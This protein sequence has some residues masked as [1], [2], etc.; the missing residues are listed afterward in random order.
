MT[1]FA[2]IGGAFGAAYALINMHWRLPPMS[3]WELLL[4]G[5]PGL[6]PDGDRLPPIE[7]DQ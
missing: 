5:E 3:L 2:V 1:A 4:W 6:F 7:D